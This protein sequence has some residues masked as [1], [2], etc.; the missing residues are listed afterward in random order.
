MIELQKF[1]DIITALYILNAKFRVGFGVGFVVVEGKVYWIDIPSD[2][3]KLYEI[4][5]PYL[6]E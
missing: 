1:C 3:E 6:N 2:M 4:V 5:K